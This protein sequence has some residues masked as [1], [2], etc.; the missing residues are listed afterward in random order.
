MGDAGEKM[1][2]GKLNNYSI[3]LILIF[4][5]AI[6]L[7]FYNFP[8]R[9]SLGEETVRDAIIGIEGARELQLPLTGSFSSLGPFTFGPLYAY[10]LFFSYL[11]FPSNYSPWV[12]LSLIAILYIYIIYKVGELL[13]G[14]KFGL[15]LAL[16]AAFSPAQVIS[17][18]HLTSHNTTNLFAILAIWIFLRIILKGGSYW[19]GFALGIAL[20]TGISFHY[21]MSG[22][23]IL[24][25]LLL[26]ARFKKY[27]YFIS[28]AFGVFIT[29]LPLLFFEL[30]NHWFNTRNII[31]YFLYGRTRIYVPNRWL[32]YLRDF[33]P[34]FWADAFGIPTLMAS[35]IILLFIGMIIWLYKNKKINISFTLLIITFLVNFIA[36]RYY[37]GNRF[38]GYLNFLRPFVFI[39][40]GYIFLFLFRIKVAKY[41]GFILFVLIIILGLPRNLFQL[42]KDSFSSEIYEQVYALESR[43]PNKKFNIYGCSNFYR[44]SYNS[45]TFS[46]VFVLD[47]KNKLS[48]KGL[49]VGLR[50]EDCQ[51]PFDKGVNKKDLLIGDM[52]LVD[53][54][55]VTEKS[56][57]K[58]GW[59]Q[60]SFRSIYELNARWWFKEQ[61]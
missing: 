57:L 12:Y 56:L 55:S 43:Y 24:L 49:K 39:F 1:K 11:F 45:I 6:F 7:R 41:L 17:A 48:D 23:L 47:M 20:G 59:K 15:I 36:L 32:F 60:V 54:S 29:F 53:F 10:Q 26:I 33:W 25:V 42:Q 46:L 44:G 19:W 28:S 5:V 61:P 8:Y 16:L 50:S 3:L 31:D 58:T 27:L 52:G 38:F 18:T 13:D 40:T 34:S 2:I 35:F 22:L 9:Y 14:K 4:L 30:N 37:W 21:Q 51:D